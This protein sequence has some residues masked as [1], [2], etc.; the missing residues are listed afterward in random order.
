MKKHLLSLLVL[1]AGSG[2]CSVSAEVL[3]LNHELASGLS[4]TVPQGQVLLLEAVV[5]STATGGVSIQV[6]GASFSF[7]FGVSTVLKAGSLDRGLLLK[8]G[9]VITAPTTG[10]INYLLFGRLA[11]VEELYAKVDA[12]QDLEIAGGQALL[13]VQADSKR[14]VRYRVEESGDLQEWSPAEGEVVQTGRAR[15]TAALET[16]G[17]APRKFLRAR[18]KEIPAD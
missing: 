17:E 4:Y 10:G 18:A 2:L 7:L 5:S 8:E 1:L 16:S 14:P 9:T 11:T 12:E 3:P 13:T 15:L 6:P